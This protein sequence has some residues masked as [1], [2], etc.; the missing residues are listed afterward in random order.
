[1]WDHDAKGSRLGKNGP[2]RLG[3]MAAAASI[4]V[5]AS[6]GSDRTPYSIDDFEGPAALQGWRFYSSPAPPATGGSLAL[7]SG[8]R[9]HGA[10]LTYRLHGGYAEA[11]WSATSSLPKRRNP[12]ISLWIRFSPEVEVYLVAKDSSGQTL[13][14]PIPAATIEHP[15]AGDWQYMVVPLAAKEAGRIK[16]RLVEIGILVQ[17]GIQASAEGRVSFDEVRLREYSETFYLDAAAQVTAPSKESLELAPRLGV[18]IHLLRDS[19]AL[20]LA[21]AAGFGFVRMDMLW[22]NVEQS[23]RYRFF[24]YDALLR[25]LEARDMGALWILDYG[26]P[27]HG[28]ATPRTPQDVAAFGRF[29]EAAAAYFK[30]RKVRYEVWNEPNI[31]QF[32]TPSPNVSEYAALLREAVA[33]IHRADPSAQVSSGGVSRMDA[34]FLSRAVDPGLAAQLSAV[35]VHPYPKAGPESIAA[36]LALFRE[37]AARAL[38][39]HVEIWNTEWGYSSSNAPREA[40]SNGHTEAGRRRQAVLAVREMLTVWTAGFPLAVWYD[41]RDDGADPANPEHNYGLLDSSGKEKPAMKAIRTLT[42]TVKDRKFAGMIQETP[43]G[44]HA[45][46]L[47]GSPDTV[48]IVWNDQPGERRPVEYDRRGMIS[49]TDLMGN[50]VKSKDVGSGRA[51]LE[52]DEATGPIYLHWTTGAASYSATLSPLRQDR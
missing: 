35:A 42:S 13:R 32:W 24:A 29:A 10:V 7:G 38:G 44:I 9:E 40:P 52:I 4:L 16:G 8:H 12:A 34:A 49:A 45:M 25:A 43:A 15:K 23:G 1:M 21:R 18:N 22:A 47:D 33:A 3:R 48:F 31:A 2:L 46:R 50:P 26:H 17:S 14:F 20:D 36:E 41:L 19:E 30:G 28:G 39:D 5:C 37:W 6:A 51:R 11:L 27:D